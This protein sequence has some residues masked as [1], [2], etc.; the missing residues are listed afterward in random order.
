MVDEIY[1]ILEKSLI[2]LGTETVKRM[3]YELEQQG[4]RATGRSIK[5]LTPKV[6]RDGSDI[7]MEI[8][9]VKSL[10]YVNDGVRGARVRYSK[11]VILDWLKV[12]GVGAND[13][14]RESIFWKIRTIHKRE[15]IPSKGSYKYSKNGHR[16]NWVARSTKDL[17]KD[18]LK[19]IDIAKINKSIILDIYK[20]IK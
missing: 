19:Y 18:A 17:Q 5:S 3:G 16:K 1:K 20:S 6:Y 10:K 8:S 4:H 14:E 9:G 15:G 13:K 11:Q 7:V 12:I 2:Q